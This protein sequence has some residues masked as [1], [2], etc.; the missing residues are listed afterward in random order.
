MTISPEWL[1]LGDPLAEARR[2]LGDD[3]CQRAWEEGGAL[4]VDE[5]FALAVPETAS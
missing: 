3:A 1:P 2:S 5:A 4:T